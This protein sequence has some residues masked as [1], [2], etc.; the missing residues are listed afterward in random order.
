M[1]ADAYSQE[2]GWGFRIQETRR[3]HVLGTFFER[4]EWDDKVDDPVGGSMDVHRVE[5]S[6]LHFRLSSVAPQLEVLD[7][8]RS[9]RFFFSRLNEYAGFTIAIS[10]Y[11]A[12]LSDW[13]MQ[14]ETKTTRLQVVSMQ[15]GDLSIGTQVWAKVRF[16]GSRDV[17][18]AAQEFLSIDTKDAQR[19]A[20]IWDSGT[21]RIRC[22]LRDDG[23]AS[24]AG[25]SCLSWVGLLRDCLG[26]ARSKDASGEK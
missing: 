8:P 19:L 25:P 4:H 11:A 10:P 5:V 16:D 21:G 14:V 9:C 2:L 17:R 13:L 3:D 22:E 18:T 7:P 15:S 20:V 26:L 1:L 12:A 23:R 6:R 24:I